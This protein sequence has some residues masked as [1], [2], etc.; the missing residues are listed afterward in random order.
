MIKK[1]FNIIMGKAF[2]KKRE[3]QILNIGILFGIG[4]LGII[5]PV[6]NSF[7][8]NRDIFDSVGII[9]FSIVLLISSIFRL[10]KLQKQETVNMR[11][12]LG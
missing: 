9:T 2:K 5:Q 12:V 3:N 11:N 10:I 7:I 1:I 4:G 8:Y 6:L